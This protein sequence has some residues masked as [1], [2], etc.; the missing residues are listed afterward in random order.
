VAIFSALGARSFGQVRHWH[1]SVALFTHNVQAVPWSWRSR[2]NLG[3]AAM[4]KGDIPEAD[5][6]TS[7]AVQLNPGYTTY[8]QLGVCRLGQNRA[9][10]GIQLAR[11]AIATNPGAP[12]A[13]QVLAE[14]FLKVRDYS[15]AKIELQSLL[16]YDP[17]DQH[18]RNAMAAVDA[19]LLR[20]KKE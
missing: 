8:L 1:D 4:L 5:R 2:V 18:A 6:Q 14:H 19:E 16:D 20:A 9:A 12:Q 7:I 15:N 10:E 13:H 11:R 17:T 3:I